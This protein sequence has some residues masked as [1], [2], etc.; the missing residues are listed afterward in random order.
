[1]PISL[2]KSGKV[3]KLSYGLNPVLQGIRSLPK[4][5]QEF[6]QSNLNDLVTRIASITPHHVRLVVDAHGRSTG[7]IRAAYDVG[8]RHFAVRAWA[9]IEDKAVHLPD[10][11]KWHVLGPWKMNQAK[12][13]RKDSPGLW[14]V[15]SVD[16]W[17]K[18]QALQRS[19]QRSFQ[20]AARLAPW[21]PMSGPLPRIHVFIQVNLGEENGTTPRSFLSS[22]CVIGLTFGWG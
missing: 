1:M 20:R 3:L 9:N 15:E 5:R 6:I 4:V 22:L 19:L 11:I 2:G 10:D 14:A 7:E 12:W 16:T 21:E 8:Q 13:L 17:P 18:A